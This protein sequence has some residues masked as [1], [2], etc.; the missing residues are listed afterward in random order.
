MNGSLLYHE[1]ALYYDLIHARYDYAGQAAALHDLLLG[2]GVPDGSHVLEAACGTGSYLAQLKRHYAVSGFDRSEA[3]LQ[4]AR[5]KLPDVPLFCADLRDFHCPAPVDAILCL[6]SA[7]AYLR[8]VDELAAAVCGFARALRHGGVLVLRPWLTPAQAAEG[9]S[10]MDAFDGDGLK[11]CRQAVLKRQGRDSILDFHWL[12]AT[13]GA[14]VAH[15]VDRHVLRLFE[16]QE[17][18]AALSQCGLSGRRI[19]LE[20]FGQPLW[21]AR[22]AGR[23]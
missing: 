7:I 23:T 1:F 12:V 10:W 20:G 9:L 21:V 4:I 3:M 22:R 13:P 6:C 17:I 16:D 18:G 19:M 11:L 14:G 8:S 15:S 5:R 2:H